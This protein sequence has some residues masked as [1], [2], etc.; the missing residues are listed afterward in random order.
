MDGH[1]L[2]RRLSETM[3][4]IGGNSHLISNYGGKYRNSETITTALM[5]SSV[6]EVV[7]N[8]W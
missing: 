4:Y 7:R 5:E 3:I 1:K 6:N 2:I 8:S